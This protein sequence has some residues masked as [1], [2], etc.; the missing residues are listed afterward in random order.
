M[1]DAALTEMINSRVDALLQ[2]S[3]DRIVEE[4]DRRG[5]NLAVDDDMRGLQTYL[6]NSGAYPNPSFDP[7]VHD[8]TSNAFW[9]RVEDKNGRVIGS[10]AERIYHCED[11]IE[12]IIESDRIWFGA[13]V[14][15][16]KETWRTN[17]TRPAARIAGS[18]GYAGGMFV[19]P[20][21]RGS[22][23]ALFLPYLSRSLCLRNYK[24]DWHTGLIHL[25]IANS[26][27]PTSYYGYPRTAHI[28]S[29]ICPRTSGG[30]KDVHFCWMDRGESI[31]KLRE[32]P[33]HPRYP[34]ALPL[35]E[36]AM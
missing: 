9:L 25:N 27:I 10:H 36:N 22:G 35:L 11:F 4:I 13:G 3:I 31:E 6:S 20:D 28:F 5:F 30:F 15:A 18:V 19:Q 12:E 21:H 33:N 16:P 7:S 14:S 23:L 32:L 24:T 26:P 8:L 34:V 17:L 29:G 1:D 2:E